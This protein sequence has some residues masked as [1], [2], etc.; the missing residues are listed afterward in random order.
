[1]PCKTLKTGVGCRCRRERACIFNRFDIEL[2]CL[3]YDKNLSIDNSISCASC[4]QQA[5]AFGDLATV[6]TGVDG[7]TG[8]HSMRLAYARFGNEDRFF[9]DER[10]PSLEAQTTQPIQDHV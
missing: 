1:M 2:V 9:W 7:V 5:A 10:A 8:R 6:S 4:H 3:F